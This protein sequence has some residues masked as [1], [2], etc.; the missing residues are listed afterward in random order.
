MIRTAAFAAGILRDLERRAAIRAA[1]GMRRIAA[2]VA[3]GAAVFAALIAGSVGLGFALAGP[4]GPAGAAFLVGLLWLVLA[5]VALIV[6]VLEH[7]RHEPPTMPDVD[8]AEAVAALKADFGE[9][10]PIVL[11]AAA[12]AGFL[13]SSRR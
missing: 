5:V 11:I 7:R 10:A 1:H 12:A 2:L 9:H 13:A 4:L 8:P 6:V 3:V